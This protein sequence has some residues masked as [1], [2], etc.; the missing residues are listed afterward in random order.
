MN[1]EIIYIGFFRKNIAVFFYLMAL[2]VFLLGV[3]FF[4]VLGHIL[5]SLLF[6]I[7]ML[8]F[9]VQWL[10]LKFLRITKDKIVVQSIFFKDIYSDLSTVKSIE[11]YIPFTSL[12]KISFS[13]D[14][15]YFFLGKSNE[16]AIL[17]I[18]RRYAIKD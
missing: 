6:F 10:I 1:N 4:L 12:M 16:Q 2:F 17:E 7:G 3:L 13:N 5:F 11:T 15:Q 14:K 8:L 9:T 18:K